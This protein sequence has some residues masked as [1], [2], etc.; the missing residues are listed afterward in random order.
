MNESPYLSLVATS[1]ND[2]HGGNTLYRTQIFVDSFLQQCR[3][4]RLRAEL[5]LVEWNPPPDRPPLADV[6]RWNEHDEWVDCRIITVPWE[7]HVL[8]RYGRVLPLFQMIAKNAGIR[9][10]RGEFVL[11]TNIDI[12]FSDE[13]TAL[14]AGRRLKKDRTYRCDRFDVDASIPVDAPLDEK[15]TFAWSHLV[16]KNRR[17][18]PDDLVALQESDESPERLAEFMAATGHF[19]V[20]T[21]GALAVVARD[22][23]PPQWLHLD[24]CGDFTMLHRDGWAAIHGYPELETFSLHIDSLGLNCAHWAGFRETALLPPAVCFHVE[25]SL[26]SGYVKEQSAPLYDRL[27][28]QGIGWLEYDAVEPLLLD[29]AERKTAID[30][31]TDAWGLR[32]IPLDETVCT[33]AGVQRHT[34][35]ASERADVLTPVAAVKPVYNADTL[36]TDAY[37]GTI[38]RQRA[39]FDKFR[40]EMEAGQ[41]KMR[42]A[43]ADLTAQLEVSVAAHNQAAATVEDF[44]VKIAQARERLAGYERLFGWAGRLGLVK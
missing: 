10:A 16:R 21:D 31:N 26:G 7:R 35:P 42:A 1:R 24:A 20:E 29:M 38:E 9:R 15:L 28:A 36:F 27:R 13:L 3:K 37:R 34:V 44:R 2:E 40:A 11:A 25:H 14:I 19:D 17:M 32:D 30:F 8:I 18:K 41:E 5:I 22:T 39:D 43:I 33:R 23:V 12:V 6:I 4:H